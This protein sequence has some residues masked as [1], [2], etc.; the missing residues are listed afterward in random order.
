MGGKINTWF[1]LL[2]LFEQLNHLVKEGEWFEED[3]EEFYLMKD[4]FLDL[5]YRE[6]P[7]NIKIKLMYVPYFK[8][9]QETKDK[10]G[11]LMRN[12][13][14]RKPFEYYLSMVEPSEDDLEI[15]EKAT[16]EMEVNFE[17]RLFCFHIPVE[18]TIDWDMDKNALPKKVWVSGKEF[19]RN[20]FLK[21]KKEINALLQEF[22]KDTLNNQALKT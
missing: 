2:T 6:K 8:Y 22:Q 11:V 15:P 4:Q 21:A 14:P 17:N 1:K 3:I 10:A 7:E 12:E 9:C 20:Q 19:H 13:F 5:I 18:R 16:I